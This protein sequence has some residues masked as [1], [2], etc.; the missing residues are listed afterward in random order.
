MADFCYQCSLVIFGQDF[1]D[2]RGLTPIAD[3]RQGK[4]ALVLCEG[5]G[6]I[7]VD[8]N[9]HCVSHD[10]LEKGHKGRLDVAEKP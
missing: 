4:G 7:Q 3:W 6:V 9:G 10:C 1:G 2:L 8:P 5:C